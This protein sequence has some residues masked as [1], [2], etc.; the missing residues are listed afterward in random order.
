MKKIDQFL[1]YQV[2]HAKKLYM[3]LCFLQIILSKIKKNNYTELINDEWSEALQLIT[4]K[5]KKKLDITYE[6]NKIHTSLQEI[7]RDYS[8]NKYLKIDSDTKEKITKEIC[9]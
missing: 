4:E 8:N 1:H 2:Y 5:I 6:N 9:G 7:L 3:K